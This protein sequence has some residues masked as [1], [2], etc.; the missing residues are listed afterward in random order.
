MKRFDFEKVPP[1]VQDEGIA[2]GEVTEDY[3][4]NGLPIQSNFPIQSR[5][6]SLAKLLKEAM[7]SLNLNKRGRR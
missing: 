4:G 5:R 3:P 1:I 6:K 2:W 7:H